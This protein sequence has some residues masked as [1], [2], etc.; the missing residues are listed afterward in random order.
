[1][2]LTFTPRRA[3]LTA[4]IALVLAM[5]PC[6]PSNAES[7]QDQANSM[8]NGMV[9]TT[10][11]QA[12]KGQTMNTYTA[13]SMF[14]RTPNK[15][16]QLLAAQ[17]PYLRT[18]NGCSGIDAFAGSFSHISADGFKDMLK[19]ITSALPGVLFQLAIKS[20]EPLL[21]DT[22]EWFNSIQT[23]VNRAN[24]SSC[25]AAKMAVYE[26][27]QMLGMATA[28]NCE[29]IA[30]LTG[31][32]ADGAAAREYCKS[33]GNVNSVMAAASTDPNLKDIPA[34]K[35][36][37]VWQSLKKMQHLDDSDREV[38]MSVTGTTIYPQASDGN[39]LPASLGPADLKTSTLLYADSGPCGVNR[40]QL[41]SC[42]SDTT[43]CLNPTYSCRDFT[44]MSKRVADI[45]ASLADKIRAGNQ[46]P[47]ATEINFVNNVPVPVYRILAAGGTV[48]NSAISESLRAQF[49]DYVAVE[50][51]H[52]MMSRMV[53]EAMTVE[54]H[55]AKLVPPQHEQLSKHVELA[56]QFI[57]QLNADR[58]VAAQK[59]Q[60]ATTIIQQVAQL[61]RD[62]RASMPQ[63]VRDLLAYSALR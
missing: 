26:G 13:G 57:Q 22:M 44:S 58:Q 3:T 31:R 21:G 4:G 5:A 27:Y 33:A 47:S 6:L 48:K 37:L 16:Y 12:F 34:F 53:T 11:P 9:N 19:G 52:A 28:K 29:Q 59:A 30:W 50:F 8:F 54:L 46:A 2:T 24:I 55:N 61:E 45:M 25:E 7:L 39:N 32:A 10:A 42:G 38:I 1:M 63:Q 18:G 49:N 40:I 36:N 15:T 17:A 14:V 51:V 35:G 56:R 41:L 23:M 62:L 43:D 60:V 20:V